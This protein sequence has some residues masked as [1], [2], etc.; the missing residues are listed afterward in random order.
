[1]ILAIIQNRAVVNTQKSIEKKTVYNNFSPNSLISN[2]LDADIFVPSFKGVEGSDTKKF[3]TEAMTKENPNWLKAIERYTPVEQKKY[4][5]RTEFERDRNRIMHSEGFD[6]LRFKTQVFPS[7]DNDMISTRSSHVFQVTDIARNISKKLGLNE[8]L[9]EAIALG[10]DIGHAPFGHDGEKSLNKIALTHRLQPFWHEKNSLRMAD[11]FLTLQN[12]KGQE[13][14][15]GL[16]YAVRDGIIN[17]CGEVDENFIKPRKDYINLYDIQKAGQVQPFTW[18]GIVVK[19]ADKIAYLGRDIEDASKIGVLNKKNHQE[20]K[21]ILKKHIPDF[22]A[23]VNNTTLMSI[24]VTDLVK[25]SS[26]QKGIGFSKPVFNLMNDIKNYNYKN[27]YLVKDAKKISQQQCDKVL[28]TIFDNYALMYRKNDT[29][30][31]LQK[32]TDPYTNNFSKWIEKYTNNQSKP[33]NYKNTA[34]YDMTDYNDYKQAIIDYISGMTD[35]YA[36]KTY[37]FFANPS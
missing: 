25:N 10:H 1:M 20:L 31:F 4:E 15:L 18:E 24:F 35:K 29:L 36:L 33:R 21:E 37:N 23:E 17:H 6:R 14:N 12:S 28:K 5:I 19:I 11:K 16:T 2:R 13:N 26:P 32:A 3:S 34:V 7:P 8:E 27:I 30:S 22:D 9:A